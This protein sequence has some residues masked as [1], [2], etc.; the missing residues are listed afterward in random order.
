MGYSCT[1][2]RENRILIH[3]YYVYASPVFGCERPNT[4][5]EY[6]KLLL[7]IALQDAQKLLLADKTSTKVA[8]EEKR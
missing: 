5:F 1:Q 7:D 6:L 8:H 2:N 4:K 3:L